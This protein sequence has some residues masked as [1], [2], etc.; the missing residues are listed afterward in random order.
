M[1]LKKTNLS[2]D[3]SNLQHNDVATHTAHFIGQV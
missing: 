1:Q 2:Q 3:K